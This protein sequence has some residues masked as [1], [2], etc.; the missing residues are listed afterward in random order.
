MLSPGAGEV[1]G[2]QREPDEHRERDRCCDSKVGILF[3]TL[4]L[5]SGTWGGT[6]TD[7]LQKS[8]WTQS[9][10]PLLAHP[11]CV[12]AFL[13]HQVPGLLLGHSRGRPVPARN[14][15]ILRV[16]GVGQGSSFGF[17]WHFQHCRDQKIRSGRWSHNAVDLDASWL[18][19]PQDLLAWSQLGA[20]R[21][22]EFWPVSQCWLFAGSTGPSWPHMQRSTLAEYTEVWRA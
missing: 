7:W 20:V 11:S 12:S 16:F 17:H 21:R 3:V 19:A 14:Y 5:C 4:L 2:R 1:Q 18:A 13:K 15:A 6:Y 22:L 9:K 8:D 10:V